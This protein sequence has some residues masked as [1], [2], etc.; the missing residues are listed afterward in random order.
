MPL[1]QVLLGCPQELCEFIDCSLSSW[2]M[3][4]STDELLERILHRPFITP[5]LER[6]LHP[7]FDEAMAR[8]SRTAAFDFFDEAVLFDY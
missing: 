1:N 5:N 3:W 2:V 7:F 8:R 6:Y 4:Q